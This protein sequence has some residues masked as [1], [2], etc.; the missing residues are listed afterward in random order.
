MESSTE[1]QGV[2]MIF[3]GQIVIRAMS[4]DF[5]WTMYELSA[6]LNYYSNSKKLLCCS[7]SLISLNSLIQQ[8]Q[9]T[10]EN[11]SSTSLQY[12]QKQCTLL[13]LKK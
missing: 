8:H 11:I 4:R 3:K 10:L 7:H 9:Q 12:L 6:G 2:T 1:L 5:G 13:A